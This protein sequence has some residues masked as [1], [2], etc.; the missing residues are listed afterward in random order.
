MISYELSLGLSIIPVLMVFGELN[1][2][3]LSAAY[4]DAE[5]L[6]AAAVG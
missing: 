3:K 4:Q 1:L 2:G 5:R 6:A